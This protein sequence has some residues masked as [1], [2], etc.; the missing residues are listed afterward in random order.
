MLNGI[1]EL[2]HWFIGFADSDFAVWVLAI[3]SFAESIFFPIP[4]DPLLIALSINQPQNALIFAVIVT[5]ASV[6]GA[7]VGHWLGARFGRPLL[8]RFVSEGKVEAVERMF[9]KYGTWAILF[10]AFTPIPYKVFAISAGIL[11]MNLR[12]FIIA[13]IIGRG[14]RF[15]LI[16]GLVF[17][18]GEE[19]QGFIESQF[20]IITILAS[21][22]LLA[23]ALLFAVVTRHRRR[24]NA[25]G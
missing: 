2:S 9:L 22:G 4:P 20:E 10:A 3:S 8:L 17:V 25:P 7:V 5:V 15:L 16:G 21:V 23:A 6:G 24:R 13:S 14:A 1:R 19:I 11:D 12:S 18:Y